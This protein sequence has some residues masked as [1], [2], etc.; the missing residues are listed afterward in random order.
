MS[1]CST[2]TVARASD[3]ARWLGVVVALKSWARDES[4]Q[5]GAS[6]RVTTRRAS[7]AVSRTS[8]RGRV[9]VLGGEVLEEAHVERR[10]VGDQDAAGRELEEGGQG[11]LDRRRV[12]HHRVGDA[13]EHRDEG[14]DLR[15]RV[16]Q[17]L[18]LAE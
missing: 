16:D 11:R 5:L 9:V 15:A 18:E 14:R 13:G 3:R 4:L 6:S 7:L 10:V 12:A 2:S 17:G 8:K 1:P